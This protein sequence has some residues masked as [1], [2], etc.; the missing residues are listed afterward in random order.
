MSLDFS[1]H[2]RKRNFPFPLFGFAA[3]LGLSVLIFIFISGGND[4]SRLFSISSEDPLTE[5]F[6]YILM[7]S[8]FLAYMLSLGIISDIKADFKFILY[9]SRFSVFIF[10]FLAGYFINSSDLPY[11]ING[12]FISVI[13]NK[14]LLLI[15]F[16]YQKRT[17]SSYSSRI[18]M[19]VT[20]IQLVPAVYI[21][22]RIFTIGPMTFLSSGITSDVIA[23]ATLAVLVYISLAANSIYILYVNRKVR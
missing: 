5:A 22:Y 17:S 2:R 4:I 21:P 13:L 16:F 20:T 11:F 6:G 3:T 10:L 9:I 14:I 8:G 18:M 15:F 1:F 23:K 12:I 7:L 19:L